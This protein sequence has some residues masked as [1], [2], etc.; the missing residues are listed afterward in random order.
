[1]GRRVL[2]RAR[3][4]R[5]AAAVEFALIMPILLV[6]VFGIISYGYM[7]SFR[8]S[9]SQAAAEGAR[10]AAVAQQSSNQV[11]DATRAMNEAL[12]SYGVS[13]G[14]NG[15]LTHGGDNVGTCAVSVATCAGEAASVRCVTVTID[16]NYDDH[17][18][19]S[20]PGVGLVLPDR[21]RYSAVA[22]VS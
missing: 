19:L 1:M 9:I 5:G 18:L 8:Q 22:R 14:T 15:T 21:L 6:L 12:N 10:A 11:A 17:P 2:R 3:A 20:V 16:Y 13:C 7:L 4:E